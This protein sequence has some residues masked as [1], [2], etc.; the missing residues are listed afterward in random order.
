MIWLDQTKSSRAGHH[1]GLMRVSAKLRETLGPAAQT[2][3]DLTWIKQTTERDWFVTAEVFSPDERP[4]WA[5]LL[6]QRPCRL[7]A[8]FHDAIPLKLPHVTWPQSVARHPGYMKMLA[9]FD[10]VWAVSE[11]SRQ[12]LVEYWRWLG[13]ETPPAVEVLDL[14]ADFS[15]ENRSPGAGDPTGRGLLCIGILEPRKNQEFLL[16]VCERLWDEG[17]QFELHLVGRVNPHFVKPVLKQIKALQK[18][19]RGLHYHGAASDEVLTGLYQ[20]TRAVVFPTLAEGCGLPVIESL[21]RGVPCVCS[22]LPVLQE[23]AGGGGV[24]LAPLN[25][26]TAWS[27]A[28]R[29]ILTDDQAHA[30][31]VHEAGTRALTTWND[32]AEAVR[33]GLA[34]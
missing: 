6:A 31:L 27:H 16:R 4:G 3:A 14:G 29:Q 32:T 22:D 10:R 9:Q 8:I 15:G 25:D 26:V 21:W 28:L 18:Q 20:R 17:L 19:H 13:I 1:S 7:A 34:D 24:V 2:V 5:E 23:N 12:E 30:R 33:A 11:Y